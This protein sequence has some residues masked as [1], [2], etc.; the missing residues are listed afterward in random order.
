MTAEAKDLVERGFRILRGKE[1]FDLDQFAYR[2]DAAMASFRQATALDPSS[3]DAWLGLGLSYGFSPTRFDEAFAAF[4]RAQ[5]IN[6]ERPESFYELGRLLLRHAETNY[7]SAEREDLEQALGFFDES[8]KLGYE[9][10]AALYNLMGTTYFRL[11]RYREAL[12][13][14]EHSAAA[15]RPE[16]WFPSTYFLAAEA[17]ELEGNLEEA[18]RWY[19]LY[20]AKGFHDEDVRLKV[21]NIKTLLENRQKAL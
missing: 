6:P 10:P 14:F 9:D 17:N 7:E 19:E 1:E 20:L 2:S 11:K 4:T 5:E 12:E 15:A 16:S 3:Y 8:A 21:R 18:V 13:C